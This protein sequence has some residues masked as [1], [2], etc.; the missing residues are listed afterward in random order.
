MGKDS[1][2]YV[3]EHRQ[4]L[5]ERYGTLISKSEV[6]LWD[7]DLYVYKEAQVPRCPGHLLR[8]GAPQSKRVLTKVDQLDK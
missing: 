3:V 8:T 6:K 1:H 7:T 2:I 4:I 5:R